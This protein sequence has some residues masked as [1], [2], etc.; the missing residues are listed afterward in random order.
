MRRDSYFI[1]FVIFLTGCGLRTA[2]AQEFFGGGVSA[3][4]AAQGGI[5]TPSSS[6]ALDALALNP[7]GLTALSG[8]TVNLSAAG[9]FAR[10]SFSNAGNSDSPMQQT[11]GLVPFGAFGA[12]LGHSRWSVGFGF[13]PDLLSSANWRYSDVP[14]TAGVS[15]GLQNEKSA[16]LAFRSAAGLG[17]SISPNLAVGAA[18]SAIYNSNTL[19]APYIFQSQP[20]LKGL[21]TLLDL[22]TS[23]VGWNTSF[24][25]R[26]KL[27]RHIELGA[28]YRTAATITSSGNATG[29]L[30]VR[31]ST[32]LASPRT[33][34]SRIARP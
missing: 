18:V 19:D 13:M 6:N 22:H 33:P 30:S 16:I 7:A 15:Y 4:T 21:K 11:E 20:V 34:P 5:Y 8:P 29:N 14:G 23:G 28:S 27:H 3:R 1:L 17:F 10:G 32:R 9:L 26:A 31:F 12:P 25:L 2:S 24:G